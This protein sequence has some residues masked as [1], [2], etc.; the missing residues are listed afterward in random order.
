MT[1]FIKERGNG[2]SLYLDTFNVL[3]EEPNFI[4]LSQ[5]YLKLLLAKK[6]YHTAYNYFQNEEWQLNVRFKP[7]YYATVFFLRDEY[8]T[9]YLRMGPELEETVDDILAE[10]AQMDFDY[11]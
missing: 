7:L 3:L 8:P 10:V 11:A 6:Q 2:H 5:I 9:E 4:D 1:S